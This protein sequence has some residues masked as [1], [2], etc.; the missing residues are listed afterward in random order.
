MLFG[1]SINVWYSFIL[2]ILGFVLLMAG[3]V[4]ILHEIREWRIWR[5]KGGS[6][7]SSKDKSRR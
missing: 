3:I 5:H 2:V 1:L 6:I 4:W 7:E